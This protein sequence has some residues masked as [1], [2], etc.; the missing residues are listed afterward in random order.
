ML[1]HFPFQIKL[2]VIGHTHV[3][4]WCRWFHIMINT[5]HCL[6]EKAQIGRWCTFLVPPAHTAM[7]VQIILRGVGYRADSV[8]L[9]F[10]W[11]LAGGILNTEGSCIVILWPCHRSH[12]RHSARSFFV[13][14]MNRPFTQSTAKQAGKSQTT[15]RRPPFIKSFSESVFS[16]WAN[17]SLRIF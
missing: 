7:R 1:L 12:L 3:Y 17:L 5:W 13:D 14:T 11:F 4:T 2:I 10:V 8:G 15:P 16:R 6:I 9:V